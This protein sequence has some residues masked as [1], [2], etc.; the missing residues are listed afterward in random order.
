MKFGISANFCWFGP[1]IT[2]LAKHT[3]ALG[4]ESMWTGEHIIIPV[5]VA[6]PVR[7]GVRLPENY[8]H[9][10][11]VFVTLTAAAVATTHL[12]IGMDVCLVTQR[13]PLILAKEAATLDHISAGRLILGVGYG[14]IE[15]ESAIMGVPFK[16][17]VRKSTETV[18]ALKTLWTEEKPSFSGEF[19]SFPP[20]YSYP[21]P[22]Q[23]PHIPILIG[24]GNHNTDNTRALKRV[25]EIGDGWVPAFLSPEQMRDQLGQLKE[26]CDAAGRDFDKMDI[27]L[28]V[29][30]INLG[31]GE[32]PAFFA[33][34]Q[35]QPKEASELIAEYEQAG[36]KRIIVGLNDMTDDAS[37]K[38]IEEAAKGLGLS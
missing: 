33:G 1:P 30:A 36:V 20:V 32:R 3:E 11:D 15:E 18:R 9:M 26:M 25:A 38:R 37:F 16:Q 29:P 2:R 31:V 7:H 28:I 14:W 19:I 10:P 23:K 34:L 13:N 24:S 21:K 4:F 5:D 22:L 8:K 17:R 6:N 27:T 12:K 35:E